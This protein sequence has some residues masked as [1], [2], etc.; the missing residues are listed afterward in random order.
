[1]LIPKMNYE[2]TLKV[3]FEGNKFGPG[4]YGEFSAAP[5]VDLTMARVDWA[6]ITYV[7]WR[8]FPGK[9]Q[10]VHVTTH[11]HNHYQQRQNTMHLQDITVY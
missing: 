7:I 3:G 5:T 8:Q 2:H 9:K 6:N 10:M 11:A 1:M 4:K